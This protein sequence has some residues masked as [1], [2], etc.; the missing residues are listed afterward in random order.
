MYC[1]LTTLN[2]KKH[3]RW[4]NKQF[5]AVNKSIEQDDLWRGRFYIEQIS[6]QFTIYEDH[7]GAYLWVKYACVDKKTGLAQLNW[8]NSYTLSSHSWNLFWFINNFI[9]D[10]IQVWENEK[11]DEDKT[12]YTKVPRVPRAQWKTFIHSPKEIGGQ[13]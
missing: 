9:V 4:L 2:R 3:Q 7:S 8:N 1:N 12:D 5:R 11:P 6:N 13:Y 10:Q